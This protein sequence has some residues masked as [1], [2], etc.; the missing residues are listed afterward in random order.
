M[1]VGIRL[2]GDVELVDGG[3]RDVAFCGI[4]DDRW[5]YLHCY[6]FGFVGYAKY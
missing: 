1:G 6:V 5:V 4:C 3:K 2:R